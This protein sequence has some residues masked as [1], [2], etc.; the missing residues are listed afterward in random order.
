MRITGDSMVDA[1]IDEGDLLLIKSA[2][3][4]DDGDLVLAHLGTR[5]EVVKRLRYEGAVRWLHSENRAQNYPPLPTDADT[6]IQG[7]VV[8]TLKGQ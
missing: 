2:K 3:T 6:I 7:R 5:G 4:A 8:G 1:G